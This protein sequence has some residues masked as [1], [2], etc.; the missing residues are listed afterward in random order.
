MAGLLSP[1]TGIID[2]HALMLAY[3]GEVEDHGGLA[4]ARDPPRRGG[5]AGEGID[6]RWPRAAARRVRL[7]P[8]ALV[9]A[10]GLFAG[11]VAAAIDGLAPAHRRE[12]FYCKGNYFGVAARV[13]FRHLIYPVPERDGLGVHLTLDMAGRGRFGPD[14]EWIDRH[15]LQPR[16]PPRRRLLRGDPPL[17]AGAP[18]RRAQPRAIPASARSSSPPAGPATDFAIEGPEVHGVPGLVNLYGIESPGLT[19]SLAIAEEVVA[20]LAD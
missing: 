6:R 2:S 9:N 19:A 15:R 17:L 4:G 20:R 13:P 7:R 16:R 11:E 1:S 12:I 10:A 5:G 14:T 18:R 3:Q 8:R